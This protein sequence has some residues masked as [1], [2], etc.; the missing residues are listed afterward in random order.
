MGAS[1]WRVAISTPIS[2]RWPTSTISRAWTPGLQGRGRDGV[3]VPQEQVSDLHAGRPDRDPPGAPAPVD[4]P[5]GFHDL[6]PGGRSIQKEIPPA[7]GILVSTKAITDQG[8][9]RRAFMLP[10]VVACTALGAKPSM[11]EPSSLARE[12][13]PSVL[14]TMKSTAILSSSL[15][16]VGR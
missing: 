3:L 7:G 8:A 11:Y 4:G 15:Y 10:Q 13:N 2:S 6:P 14:M 5:P 1:S 9:E 12:T 16:R